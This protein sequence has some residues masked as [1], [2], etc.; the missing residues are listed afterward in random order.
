MLFLG[1]VVFFATSSRAA[2]AQAI[3]ISKQYDKAGAFKPARI[4]LLLLL[5]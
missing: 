1:T 4:R 2:H 3:I 5:P